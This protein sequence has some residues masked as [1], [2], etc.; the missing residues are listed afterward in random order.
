M[1]NARDQTRHDNTACLDY[2]QN[3]PSTKR[4]Q[5]LKSKRTFVV[6]SKRTH[7]EVKTYLQWS[8]NVPS[9]SQNVLTIPK[10]KCKWINLINDFFNFWVLTGN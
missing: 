2:S 4:T 7:S 3:V 8:Q 9:I 10:P 6:K 1:L 5:G